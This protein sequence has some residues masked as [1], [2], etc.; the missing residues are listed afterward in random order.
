MLFLELEHLEIT[1][2]NKMV[3]SGILTFLYYYIF[4]VPFIT[5]FSYNDNFIRMC[6]HV[7]MKIGEVKESKFKK[8][9]IIKKSESG[10]EMNKVKFTQEF[11]EDA[12]SYYHS[13]GKSVREV[14][15]ELG[16]GKSTLDNW[17]RK[18][19][20]NNGKIEVRGSGNYASDK[21]KE[22]SKLQKEL[23]DTKD[24]LEILKKAMGILNN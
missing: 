6:L 7:R 19:R 5:P 3:I 11:K 22:I 20:H 16:I 17:I 24:A 2:V 9:G 1:E 15:E 10:G 8:N 4:I 12:V 21:D 14:S 13:S 18:S 23:K